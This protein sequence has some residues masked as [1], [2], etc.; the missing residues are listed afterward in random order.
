[1]DVIGWALLIFVL[2]MANMALATVRMLIMIRGEK[3]LSAL[4]GFFEALFFVVAVGKTVMNI[5]NLANLLA[6]CGGFAAGTLVGMYIEERLALGYVVVRI[7]SL[8][9]GKEVALHLRGKGY[10]VMEMSGK[11][12]AGEVGI[13]EVVARRK[14]LPSVM[15]AATEVDGE[16]FITVQEPRGVWR[17]YMPGVR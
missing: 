12:R 2:R 3:W 8:K 17:G 4:I 14:D 10:G 16:A 1:M 13:I 9:M 6:Y 7:V 15:A 5:G 11:G